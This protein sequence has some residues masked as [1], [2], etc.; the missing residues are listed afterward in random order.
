M[1]YKGMATATVSGEKACSKCKERPRA[2]AESTN[3]WCRECLA[4]Y[5]AKHRKDLEIQY[6]HR[7]VG[8]MRASVQNYFISLGRAH[9]SSAE[10][11]ALV[12]KLPGPQIAD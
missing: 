9:F 8:A 4:D 1:Y 11:A 6:L 2:A 10:V 5:A 7:G 12:A 3:P